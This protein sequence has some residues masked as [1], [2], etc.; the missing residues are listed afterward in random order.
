MRALTSHQYGWGS[1]SGLWVGFVLDFLL[2]PE[3]VFSP[4]SLVVSLKTNTSKYQFDLN[5]QSL[6][7]EFL[8]TSNYA[9][10]EQIT[11]IFVIFFTIFDIFL[12]SFLLC[13]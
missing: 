6:F 7:K 2:C 13:S 1:N 9:M 10:G 11:I 8:R 12:M 5:A 3:R 4:V